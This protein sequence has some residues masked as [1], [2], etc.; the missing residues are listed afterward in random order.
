LGRKVHP[1]GFRLGIIR[2]WKARWFAEGEQYTEQLHEDLKI[3]DYVF[4]S[5]PRAGIADVELER[6]PN[7][8]SVT[9]HTS[10]P[11]IIIGR[12]GASVN[13]LKEK[14]EKLTKKHVRVDVREVKSPDTNARLIADNVASQLEHRISHRRAMKQATMRAMRD[15]AKGI[16]IMCSGRLSGAEMARTAF[17]REGRV[18]LHTL[19]ADIDYALTEAKT[20]YGKIGVKVWVYK[21]DVLSEQEE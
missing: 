17:V 13:Q 2:D 8:V 10:K 1:Y 6:F 12:K 7:Q 19:R 5:M 4:N 11:G 9:I 21:G 16:K 3:R 20:T 15:G 14:L 18:P